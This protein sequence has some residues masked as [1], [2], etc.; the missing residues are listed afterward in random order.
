MLLSMLG[1][2]GVIIHHWMVLFI[3]YLSELRGGGNSLLLNYTQW[4][5]RDPFVSCETAA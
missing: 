1:Y 4:K 2:E 3:Q 5:L